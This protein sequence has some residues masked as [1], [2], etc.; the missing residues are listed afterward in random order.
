MAP[1][2]IIV[3]FRFHASV[4]IPCPIPP[5]HRESVSDSIRFWSASILH[6]EEPPDRLFVKRARFFSMERRL[7][8]SRSR[9]IS[10]FQRSLISISVVSTGQIRIFRGSRPDCIS[11]RAISPR[12]AATRLSMPQMRR[13]WG[14]FAR[15]TAVLIMQFIPIVAYSFVRNVPVSWKGRDT[16]KKQEPQNIRMRIICHVNIFCIR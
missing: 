7:A 14:V 3:K 4:C 2:R 9:R 11:G 10:T 8:V 16:R 13:C 1:F 15:V 5:L 6:V 12:C